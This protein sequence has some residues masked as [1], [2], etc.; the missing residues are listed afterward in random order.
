MLPST[1]SEDRFSRI[2]AHPSLEVDN[3]LA[4]QIPTVPRYY[5]D[6]IVSEYGIAHLKGKHNSE[7]AQALI[8][9]AHPNARGQLRQQAKE[10]GL[11]WK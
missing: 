1:S 5:A 4:P 10:L 9:I 11:L 7:R 2:V 6:Y 3:P 8:K